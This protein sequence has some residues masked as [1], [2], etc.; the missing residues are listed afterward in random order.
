MPNSMSVVHLLLVDLLLWRGKT[1]STTSL[2]G[3][4]LEFDNNAA[5]INHLLTLEHDLCTVHAHLKLMCT[6]NFSA[7]PEQNLLK[8]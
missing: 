8:L 3:L 1:K 7:V 4:R 5:N 6:G 2:T